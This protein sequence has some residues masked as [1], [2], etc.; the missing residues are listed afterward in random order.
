MIYLI[1]FI[2][3]ITLLITYVLVKQRSKNL[4]KEADLLGL[5]FNKNGRD[6]TLEKHRDFSLFS[7]GV[8]KTIT[9]EI[10][11]E[12]KGKNLSVFGY[13]Y[14]TDTEAN[15]S[16]TVNKQ[17][18]ISIETNNNSI[19]DFELVPASVFHKLGTFF[20]DKKVELIAHPEFSKKF[21]LRGDDDQGIRDFFTDSI[22]EIFRD[23]LDVSVESKSNI[24]LLYRNSKLCKSSE[25]SR[26]LEEGDD[27]YRVFFQVTDG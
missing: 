12:Y 5:S 11:G 7:H 14:S 10:W 22:V 25:I 27:I 17:T 6:V 9:N 26:F 2:V 18:L 20:N 16:R 19:P 8:D 24:L 13:R 21:L 23:K 3:G 1:L 4:Q 15:D